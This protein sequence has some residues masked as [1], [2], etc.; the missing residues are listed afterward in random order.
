MQAGIA[1]MG[2]VGLTPQSYSA[3]GGFIAQGRTA[4]Q[5][6]EV[7]KNAKDVENAGAFACVIECVPAEVAKAV[8]E[9]LQI[10][11]IGIGSGKYTDGQVLVYHD[12]LGMMQHHH[13]AQFTPSFCKQYATVGYNIQVTY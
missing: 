8:T 1:V 13:H 12:L 7:V 5:A 6:L 9:R 2:H 4:E 3:L 11:T 10:P